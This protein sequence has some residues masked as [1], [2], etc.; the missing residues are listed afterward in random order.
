MRGFAGIDTLWLAKDKISFGAAPG[1]GVAS[2]VSD[3]DICSLMDRESVIP[4]LGRGVPPDDYDFGG[5]SGGPML[6]VVEGRAGLRSWW[7]AGVIYEGP[8]P[9]PDANEAIPGLQIIRARRMH[10][11]R[12]DGSIDAQLWDSLHI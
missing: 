9:A 5:I 10:F 4:V 11:I 2:S 7:P 3:K 8:N 1:G 6:A 12:A